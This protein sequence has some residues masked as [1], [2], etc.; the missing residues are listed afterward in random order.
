M[1]IPIWGADYIERWLALSF[2]SLR[3]D[4]NIPELIRRFDFELA[5]VTKDADAVAMRADPRFNRM[6]EGLRIV[7]ISMDEFFPAHDEVSYGIP[8]T[9]AYGKAILDLGE[10]GIGSFVIVMTAD[11]MLSDGSL[12]NLADRLEAGYTIVTAPSI[13][14]V[15]EEVRPIL[16]GR[17]DAMA[18]VMSMTSRDMM[19]VVN[20]HLHNT[21]RARTVNEAEFVDSTYYHNI[22]WRESPDCLAAHYFLLMPLCFQLQRL[23]PK[24]LCPIDYG[25]ITEICPDGRFTVLADSDDL[26]MLELQERDSQAYLLRVAPPATS[27]EERLTRLEREIAVTTGGWATAEQRR[28]ASVQLYFHERDLP[29][30]IAQ[31]TA[32]FETFMATIFGAMPPPVQ[33]TRHFH[34]LGDVRNY[35]SRMMRGG[36][37]GAVTLLD[38]PRNDVR[39]TADELRRESEWTGGRLRQIVRYALEV[40]MLRSS[41]LRG[42]GRSL[43]RGQAAARSRAPNRRSIV[44]WLYKYERRAGEKYRLYQSRREL[45]D[46]LAAELNSR[47]SGVVI[48]Y[49]DAVGDHLPPIP[50]ARML[51]LRGGA[52]GEQSFRLPAEVTETAGDG[53]ETLIVCLPVGRFVSWAGIAADVDRAM[54]RYRRVVIALIQPYFADAR[55]Q[56]FSWLLSVMLGAFAGSQCDIRIEAFPRTPARD[57]TELLLQALFPTFWLRLPRTLSRLAGHWLRRGLSYPISQADSG[58]DRFSALLIHARRR[59]AR[60]AD[61]AA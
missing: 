26:V 13:R 34:W 33:H 7:F 4:G 27:L 60:P 42:W 46:Y 32:R 44:G 15:D 61:L 28:S 41:R 20:A 53:P 22:Y 47:A 8:L 40:A 55:M 56:D 24:V 10:A 18:G 17:A 35:R 9:L 54:A 16:L 39:P 38:D 2:A 6:T 29:V 25:F 52:P 51:R 45:A 3:A 59:P 12:K 19:G 36:A 57:R 21:V 14:V 43:K 23:M 1:I 58:P 11:M 49:T 37:S 48:A 5:L 30:D 31:R 50:G